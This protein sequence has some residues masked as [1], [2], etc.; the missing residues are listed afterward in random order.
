MQRARSKRRGTITI[1]LE[2]DLAQK[3]LSGYNGTTR[4]PYSARIDPRAKTDILM[5]KEGRNE[6]RKLIATF[7]NNVGVGT[8]S[9]GVLTPVAAWV[10]GIQTSA[11]SLTTVGTLLGVALGVGIAF[12]AIGRLF[13]IRYEP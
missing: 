4:F 3:F 7:F 6:E 12:H 10:L 2:P 11:L 9:A 5:S 8:I 13:L 1:W